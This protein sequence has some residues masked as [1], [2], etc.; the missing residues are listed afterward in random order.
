MIATKSIS[1][2]FQKQCAEIDRWQRHEWS[3]DICHKL[4]VKIE[5][6]L[7]VIYYILNVKLYWVKGKKN[8]NL[9]FLIVGAI[10]VHY[11]FSN[12]VQIYDFNIIDF[13]LSKVYSY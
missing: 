13:S 12:L 5:C 2:E 8:E 4:N 7:F 10:Y 1:F 9:T 11:I 6:I 3:Y